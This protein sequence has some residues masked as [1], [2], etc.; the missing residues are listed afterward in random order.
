MLCLG[1]VPFF[2]FV[3]RTNIDNLILLRILF[4]FVDGYL[5]KFDNLH[6]GVVPGLHAADEIPCEFGVSSS[7][8]IAN[9]FLKRL[10]AFDNKK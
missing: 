10:F 7:D 6:R 4:E 1:N 5:V 3:W 9:H 2:P 8:Q